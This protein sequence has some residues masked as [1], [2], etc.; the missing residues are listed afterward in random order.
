MSTSTL[1]RCGYSLMCSVKHSYYLHLK[2]LN[3]NYWS[4]WS[5]TNTTT[6][7]SSFQIRLDCPLLNRACL[8]SSL[9]GDDTT[10]DYITWPHHMT[11]QCVACRLS[12]VLWKLNETHEK[13]NQ[14]KASRLVQDI[15]L[16]TF[17][18]IS[19]TTDLQFTVVLVIWVICY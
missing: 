12:V 3:V 6:L 9:Q 2:Y 14:W 19:L 10:H 15:W 5:L 13:T 18:V 17:H 4:V 8:A 7:Y 1:F 11:T 16:A